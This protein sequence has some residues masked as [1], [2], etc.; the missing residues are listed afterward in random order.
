MSM[1]HIAVTMRHVLQQGERKYEN[2]G[3]PVY[4]TGLWQE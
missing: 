1:R 3:I 2:L 4:L